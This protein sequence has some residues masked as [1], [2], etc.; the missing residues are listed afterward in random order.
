MLLFLVSLPFVTVSTDF[1]SYLMSTLTSA[2]KGQDQEQAGGVPRT[3]LPKNSCFPHAWAHPGGMQNWG[4]VA[5]IN[6]GR[7]S[8]RHMCLTLSQYAL[9]LGNSQNKKE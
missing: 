8:Q 1:A 4:E 5:G 6:V 2:S 9:L 7:E 3:S